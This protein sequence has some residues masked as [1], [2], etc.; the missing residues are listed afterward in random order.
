MKGES[1]MSRLRVLERA[2]W[3]A[4]GRVVVVFVDDHGY[5]W[6]PQGAPRP[7]DRVREIHIGGISLE[8][9]V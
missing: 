3:G 6:A 9:D 5:R 7:G 4:A 8:R 2:A 1:V